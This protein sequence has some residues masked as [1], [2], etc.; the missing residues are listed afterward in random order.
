MEE[1]GPKQHTDM[2]EQGCNISSLNSFSY[3]KCNRRGLIIN[4]AELQQIG[5]T[6]SSCP[7]QYY[8]QSD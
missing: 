3:L 8:C 6:A 4:S 2:T 1:E 7:E 5:K